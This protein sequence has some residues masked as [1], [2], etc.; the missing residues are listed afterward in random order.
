[1]K[2]STKR[3]IATFPHFK[4]ELRSY[5]DITIVEEEMKGLNPVEMTFF[6]L[7]CFFEAPEQR[8]FDIGLLYQ[9]LDNDW[10]ELALELITAYFKEDTHLIQQPT[11]SIIREDHF[12]NQKQFAD[13][14]TK[15]GLN[16]D[17]RKLNVYYS[18]GKVPK[19]DLELAGIPY[20]NKSTVEGFCL[21]EK[22]R[23]ETDKYR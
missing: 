16:Y 10:L 3:I 17:K 2:K 13:Y 21:Q 14:L 5:E 15:N 20:W 8:N 23:L 19:A 7:A 18:R 4:G 22:N 1:M 12:F 11:I 6:K 9:H